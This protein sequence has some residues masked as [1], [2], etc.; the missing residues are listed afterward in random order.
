MAAKSGMT[1]IFGNNWQMT[2]CTYE[3]KLWYK[4]FYL[5]PFPREKYIFVFNV[6]IQNGHQK[7]QSDFLKTGR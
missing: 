7:W 6:E 1:M 4:S 3:P 5:A 2:A